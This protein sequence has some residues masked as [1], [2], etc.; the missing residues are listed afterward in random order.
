MSTAAPSVE[1][2][3]AAAPAAGPAA[4]GSAAGS[5]AAPAK[6]Q[7]VDAKGGAAVVTTAAKTP[8]KPAAGKA[9]AP[10][11]PKPAAGAAAKK[12]PAA[13][14]ADTTKKRK[15][16]GEEQ[17]EEEIEEAPPAK[18]G[19]AAPVSAKRKDGTKPPPPRIL[20]QLKAMQ[21]PR[22]INIPMIKLP[23]DEWCLTP[24]TWDW[25]FIGLKAVNCDKV[26]K[27]KHCRAYWILPDGREAEPLMFVKGLHSY[28]SFGWSHEIP[29][30]EKSAPAIGISADLEAGGV[31]ESKLDAGDKWMLARI[32]DLNEFLFDAKKSP[33][34]IEE[35]YY[36][37]KMLKQGKISEKT[38]ERNRNQF[39]QKVPHREE[40]HP[41]DVKA[42]IDR[43]KCRVLSRHIAIKISDALKQPIAFESLHQKE[44]TYDGVVKFKGLAYTQATKVSAQF[45]LQV[46]RFTLAKSR[47]ERYE[48]PELPAGSESTMPDDDGTNTTA[49]APGE[50]EEGGAD[51]T[52]AAADGEEGGEDAVVDGEAAVEEGAEEQQAEAGTEEEEGAGELATEGDGE[53][54]A[55]EA[56]GGEEAAG[57]ED[58]NAAVI[59]SA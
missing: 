17:K 42:K 25:A 26:T 44:S 51:T 5:A 37:H 31:L 18:G 11:K 20:A 34:I 28:Y 21:R 43:K 24:E 52:M 12:A 23:S 9:A 33:A 48:L 19:R 38:G 15:A 27:T 3:V 50:A 30:Y 4:V 39:R 49:T 47:E 59:S 40:Y 6:K 57:E 13:S 41:D 16:E 35:E 7:K 2:G 54:A 14:A 22:Q 55:A 8:A 56:E 45:E 36:V 29:G 32:I 53:A 58:E 10:A 46:G 1:S